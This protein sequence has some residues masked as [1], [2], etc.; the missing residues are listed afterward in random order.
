[1]H[2]RSIGNIGE[3][4]AC[5]YLEQRGFL[6]VA[7]NY[8]KK[9]GEIDVVASKDK[10]LHFFEIKS[11]TSDFEGIYNSHNPEDNVHSLK[12]RHMRRAIE[13]YLAERGGTEG[14]IQ[15]HVLCVFLNMDS[16]RARVKWIRNIII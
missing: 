14:E 6:V 10:G 2:T 3:N 11:V 8:Y 1:M 15:V 16:R 9:W 12:V 7:R 5:A 13:T 4:V